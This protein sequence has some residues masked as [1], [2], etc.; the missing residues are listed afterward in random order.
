MANI[1]DL[2]NEIGN[3][4][5]RVEKSVVS[6][7]STVH[8]GIFEY[9][10]GNIKGSGSG[11]IV[12]EDGYILTNNHV[13]QHS[14]SVEII[15]SDGRKYN[16]YVTG[17]DPE[18]DLAVVKIDEINLPVLELGDSDTVKTG[19]IVL[20]IGNALG[21]PG[22]HTVSMGVISAKNRPMP[23]SDFIFEGLIQT[24]AAINPGNSGGPLVNMEGKAIGINT[25]IIAQAS[26]IGFSI[27]SGTARRVMDDLI[28]SGHVNRQ[29]IGISGIEMNEEIA[30][31][32]N[33]GIDHGVLVARV[34]SDSP[35]YN[36]DLRPGDVILKYGNNEI[37]S[38]KDLIKEVSMTGN[39]TD[40]IFYR[41]G[42]KYKTSIQMP[43]KKHGKTV[44]IL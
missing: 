6:I 13:V 11:F 12:R 42:S 35:A 1:Y 4:V 2:N 23:W 17:S 34:E 20:A 10:T 36:S 31:R 24:D 21:L 44:K 30:R 38:M 33:T 22:G 39:G 18:T 3:I 9:G 41:K 25:A 26:G 40:I 19:S 15:L 16:G 27:P 8:A 14:D 28:K 43:E 5:E 32:Y 29:Y 7:N 37:R